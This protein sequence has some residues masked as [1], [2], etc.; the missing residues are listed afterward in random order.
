MKQCKIHGPLEA[1]DLKIGIYKGKKY[2]KCKKCELIRS[3][4]YY[5]KK[6]QDKEFV[7]LKN[8]NDR[9]RWKE[10]KETITK[11][12]QTP[13]SKAKRNQWYQDNV[14]KERTRY[15]KKQTKYKDE[16]HDTYVKKVIQSGDK[17]LKFSNIPPQLVAFK[18]SLMLLKR[19]IR[20]KKIDNAGERVNENKEYRRVKRSYTGKLRKAK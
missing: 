18:R 7:A 19:G 16:L 5:K 13:E 8:E 4:A 12:R 10:N 1:T 9:K 17:N 2:K 15:R 3:R 14:D 20:N 11:K 6:Y